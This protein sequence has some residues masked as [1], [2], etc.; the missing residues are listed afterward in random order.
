[1]CGLT[2]IFAYDE[3]ASFVDSD[4]LRVM[5]EHMQSRGPDGAGVWVSNDRR[6]GL[7]H[8]RLSII[9]ISE[10]GAQPMLD[11]ESGN[12][13]VFNGEIYNYQQLRAELETVG[14]CFRSHSDTE[15]LLKLYAVHGRGMLNKLRGMYAF[16]IWDEKE[17]GLF[18]ARDPFGIKPLYIADN[19][20]TLRIASQVKALLAGGCIDLTPE[21]AGH[22]GFFLWGHVP[23]PYTFYK[24]IRALPAGTSLWIDRTG[25]KEQK[26]FFNLTQEFAQPGIQPKII[27]PETA[28]EQLHAALLDSV[29][30][31]LI[32]DVPVG[33]F[34]SSGLDS[35]TLAALAQEAGVAELRTVTLGFKE[36]AGTEND[37]VP[38][39]EV[40]ARHYGATHQTQWV[41]KEDFAE[42]LNPILSAMDQPSIDG[43]NS[44]FVCLAAKNAGLKVAISGL[45]GDELFGG[46]THFRDI[47]RMV[48]LLRPLSLV[49]G[50]GRSFRYLSAPL[51]KH[52]TP[53]KLAGL[54]EYG[55]EYGGAYLLR[56][57]FYMP[58]ELPSVLDSELIRE[59]W[60]ELATLSH[61]R[62]MTN[63]V[64]SP[65]LKVSAMDTS[66]YMRNQLLRDSDWASMAHSL[67]V[68]VPLVD[69]ELTRTVTRLVHTG[70]IPS[71]LDM[72]S[73]PNKSLPLEV[74]QRKKTGFS[75][76]VR[77][78]LMATDMAKGQT[79]LRGLRGWAKTVYAE[80]AYSASN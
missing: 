80:S 78:W 50:L 13:I 39:A 31:H 36:F 16:A 47:P 40:I 25:R 58:W 53:P 77:E 43:V 10:A 65:H 27:S 17:R 28:R 30:H 6:V 38:L 19:G 73:A 76:P 37:E 9:D 68:R 15:V 1:M 79:T 71:K 48:G 66:W 63:G 52:F 45:G 70:F 56:R 49:P 46:Y 57:G 54:F 41:R 22:V 26:A 12:R 74:L 34:L 51:L 29:R 7:A 75:V 2:A 55:G 60:R 20:Q 67:E 69:L 14:C 4:E 33:V 59:G 8:R 72:A 3:R 62:N 11:Q 32:A 23:E 24:G 18:I 35:A 42:N 21:P 61:L 5:R 44:Y 64:G